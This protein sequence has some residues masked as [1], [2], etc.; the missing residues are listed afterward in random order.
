MHTYLPNEKDHV[1]FIQLGVRQLCI[2]KDQGRTMK[3]S[4]NESDCLLFESEIRMR[5]SGVILNR[6]LSW[7]R[8][9]DLPFDEREGALTAC[10]GPVDLNFFLWPKDHVH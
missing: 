8:R 7:V 1:I 3:K 4:I 5:P 6:I 2:T 10:L 9:L